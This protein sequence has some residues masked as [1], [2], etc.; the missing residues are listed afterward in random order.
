MDGND[1][2][3][4]FGEYVEAFAA[5]GRGE[6]DARSL[7]AH[8]GVPLLL[9]T[10]HG[11]AP[12]MTEDQVVAAAQQQIDEMRAAAYGGSDILGFE[13]TVLNAKSALYRG[14]ISRQR[15]D[16]AE[17]SRLTATYL[18]TDGPVGRRISGLQVHGP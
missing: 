11:F 15:A 2:S 1:I 18:L 14:E 12:L 7:L 8:W 13:V 17:I 16:G 10:D 9:A 5:C 4:W 3:R 6:R